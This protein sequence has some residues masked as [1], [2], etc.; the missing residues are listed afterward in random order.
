M[1]INQSMIYT[2]NQTVPNAKATVIITHSIALHSIYYRKLADLLNQGG[3]NVVLYDV[4]G[5]GNSQGKR[6]DIK[7]VFI[8]TDDLHALVLETKKAYTLPV[9]PSG[10]SIGAV[11]TNIY[12]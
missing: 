11:I 10:N 5:H 2:E 8:F 7:S 6:G 4:R 9:Y 12:K 3:F 1:L